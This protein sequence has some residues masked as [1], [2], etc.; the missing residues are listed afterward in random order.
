M[1]RSDNDPADT[2]YALSSG[3]PPAAIG[4]IRVS[5]P[6]AG[7]A[8][9]RLAG[10]L[11]EPRRAALR[12]LR[13]EAGAALDRALA[14]WFPG[15]ESATG[16]DLAELHVHGGRAVIEAVLAA[17][18][19]A[20]LRLAEPGEFTRRALFN[21]R[22][23][24]AEAEGLADLLSAETESQRREALARAN[25]ALSRKLEGWTQALL[26]LAARIEA[27]IDYD[28]EV[29]AAAGEGV[30]DEARALTADIGRALAVPPAERLRDGLRVVIAGPP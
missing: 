8:L 20:G 11:P 5:G 12:L 30:R 19:R 3:R 26:A 9:A 15:P 29:E 6:R 24:L 23:D 7:D 1:A 17:L 13:D 25:G 16:E 2:I 18:G 28:D 4:I 22:I 27:A 21:G 14:L 10:S